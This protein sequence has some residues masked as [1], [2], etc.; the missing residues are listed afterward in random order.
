M[1]KHPFC[2]LLLILVV[3]IFLLPLWLLVSQAL[4]PSFDAM[5]VTL[6]AEP[7]RLVP[8]P[9]S[10]EQFHLLVS[11]RTD[12]A[13]IICRDTVCC[14]ISALVQVIVSVVCGYMLAKYKSRFAKHTVLLY[15]ITLVL[16]MQMFLIPV[17]RIAEWVG[18]AGNPLFMYFMAAF[19]PLGAILMRQVFVKMPDEWAESFRLEDIR[20]SRMLLHIVFPTGLPAA[21]I[22]FLFS[23]VETWSMIEQPL[24]LIADK[25]QYPLSM[26]LFDMR[27]KEPD[28]IFAAS[29]TA[30]IPAA[31]LI[32]SGIGI[33][34][35]SR[36]QTK[37][38][39]SAN[40]QKAE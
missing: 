13:G 34:M 20:M 37:R 27:T 32:L 5:L 39:C 31:V 23:F 21:G 15:T 9:P 19:S 4:I 10:A 7:I 35:I 16:P 24:L 18:T 29:L 26:L 36:L 40:V 17:Y 3:I 6:F 14:L 30:L 12:L 1:K 8:D 11:R 2:T 38:V 25:Q 22:L 33:L 28:V